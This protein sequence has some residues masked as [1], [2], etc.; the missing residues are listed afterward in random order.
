M[1]IRSP[2]SALIERLLAESDRR[3]FL[4][5]AAVEKVSLALSLPS[6]RGFAIAGQLE[7]F[8]FSRPADHALG[9]CHGPA[10]V[11]AGSRRLL[12]ATEEALAGGDRD[13]EVA[14]LMG[15]PYW[16][17]P[18]MAT[19]E[20]SGGTG[21]VHKIDP[22]SAEA[23]ISFSQGE[24]A[25]GIRPLDTKRESRKA[26]LRGNSGLS[27]DLRAARKNTS[28]S[29][30]LKTRGSAV[31]RFLY[32]NE[33]AAVQRLI[34]G[35]RLLNPVS[36]YELADDIATLVQD[37]ESSRLVVCDVGGADPENGP[38]P[39]LAAADPFG[40][41]TGMLVAARAAG[42]ES[43]LLFVPYEDTELRALFARAI[44]GLRGRPVLR[45]VEIRLFSAP[46]LIPCDREI[47]IASLYRGLTLSEGVSMARESTRRLWGFETVMSEPE[48]FLKLSRLVDGD[49]GSRQTKGAGTRL[50]SVGGRVKE[51]GIAE[52]SMAAI[53]GEV[54]AELAGGLAEGSVL[55]AVHFGGAYG[56]P[57]RPPALKSRLQNV[58]GRL[59]GVAAGQM[60]VIDRST[61]M[62]QWSEY[63][64]WL[65][66]R[67]CCGACVPG[68]L[69]PSYVQR[70]LKKIVMGQ[71][72]LTDLEEIRATV[73]LMKDGS[74]CAQGSRVLNPV[75][76]C[77]ENFSGEFEEHITERKC[78]AGVCW[79]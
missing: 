6:S 78:A 63:F 25:S 20:D 42:S 11:L 51:P 69:G 22:D 43:A 60:L 44:D 56:G 10:C 8:R 28:V 5:A 77:L 7:H 66:E 37:D 79:P 48:V 26:H 40:V 29:G 2:G 64:A 71:G 47:G 14:T 61:C 38:G 33:P 55:K 30:Y 9:I 12:S 62:V 31:K 72:E 45:G 19:L 13:M 52:A 57:L 32:E 36:G 50:L 39:V 49:P 3:R 53:T 24:K 74:L 17:L 59:D 75:I 58:L 76:V 41:I 16:H 67:L 1:D 54:I 35:L 23:L 68:R 21:A 46:N 70:L 73:E 27:A 15:S 65:G 34:R 18:I 4:D